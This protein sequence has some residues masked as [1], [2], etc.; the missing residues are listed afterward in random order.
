MSENA[1]GQLLGYSMQFPRAL[2]RILQLEPNGGVGV[3]ILGDVA[4]FLPENKKILEEDKSSINKNPLTDRSK[5][6]WKTFYNWINIINKEELEIENVYFVLYCNQIGRKSLVNDFDQ[7]NNKEM[8][9][10]AIKKAKETLSDITQEHEIWKFYDFVINKNEDLFIELIQHFELQTSDDVGYDGIRKEIIKKNIDEYYIDFLMKSLTGW[11]QKT[12]SEKIYNNEQ[13]FISFKMF[14]K[15]FNLLFSKI[16]QQALIDFASEEPPNENEI[17][18]HLKIS[19][20]YIKQ[21]DFIECSNDDIIEAVADYLRA[22]INRNRWI[23]S[24]ILDE[25]TAGDFENKLKSF[26]ANTKKRIEIIH[27][28][29]EEKQRGQLLMN[30]C[31]SRQETIGDMS[32]PARTIQGTYHALSNRKNIGWHPKWENLFNEHN[33]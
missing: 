20:N 8:S 17:Q 15:E 5:D 33:E 4:V 19:P 27:R 2:C 13:A 32:P 16:R 28:G 7:V 11:L 31:Q 18:G 3:E 23:E 29:L 21:L 9:L 6:L 25:I 24:E 12:I 22:E 1:A 30:E 14:T 10:E 26:W